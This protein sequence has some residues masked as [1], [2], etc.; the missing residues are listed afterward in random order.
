[1][2]VEHAMGEVVEKDV[3]KLLLAGI[4]YLVPNSKWV[5]PVPIVAKEGGMMVVE[6]SKNELIPQQ[7]VT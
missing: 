2:K 3:L 4:I 5:S 7:T 1:M 6:N